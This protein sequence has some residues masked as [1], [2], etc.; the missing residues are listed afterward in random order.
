MAIEQESLFIP[1][2]Y[3]MTCNVNKSMTCVPSLPKPSATHSPFLPLAA[4][5]LLNLLLYV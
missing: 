4:G 1:T 2:E 3:L 5:T